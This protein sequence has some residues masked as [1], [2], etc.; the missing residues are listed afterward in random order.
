[1]E[2]DEPNGYEFVE[3]LKQS[4]DYCLS[5]DDMGSIHFEMARWQEWVSKWKPILDENGGL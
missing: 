1:M 3:A 5:A 4:L 2:T